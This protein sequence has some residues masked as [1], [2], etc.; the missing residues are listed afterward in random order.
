MSLE[1]GERYGFDSTVDAFTKVSGSFKGVPF[2][3]GSITPKNYYFSIFGEELPFYLSKLPLIGI[4][5]AVFLFI[6]LLV[7]LLRSIEEREFFSLANVKRLRYMGLT[8]MIVQVAVWVYRWLYISF[9]DKNLVIEGM[10]KISS[11]FSLNFD[12]IYSYFFLG[13]MILLIANAFEHGLKLKE[14][15]ELTI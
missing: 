9:I 1:L 11:G 15:Q 4:S 7:K 5:T 13:L 6:S 10:Y 14:E 8:F 3:S 12:F 2:A